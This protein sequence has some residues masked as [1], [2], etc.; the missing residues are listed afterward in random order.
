MHCPYRKPPNTPAATATTPSNSSP[1]AMPS[2][3]TP[4]RR[5][6]LPWVAAS[7]AVIAL[8][9]SVLTPVA[10]AAPALTMPTAASH[11]HAHAR[12]HHALDILTHRDGF[13]GAL[14]Q[15][16][17]AHGRRW[18]AT[19]GVAELGSPRPMPPNGRFRIGSTTKTFVATVVLQLAA[20]HHIRLDAPVERYLPGLV[21]G[22]GNDGRA[23]TVRQLL[24]HTSGLP[25]YIDD[26]PL[27]GEQ[28][29]ADR[30]RH[31]QP[32]QLVALALQHPPL[33]APSTTWSYSN[34][35]YILAGLLIE[36]VTG[37]PYGEEITQRILRPLHLDHTL[38]PGDS[39]DI[40]GPHAH[41]YLPVG[42]DATER[43]VDITRINPSWSWAAGE[44]LSTSSDLNRFFAALLGGRLLPAAELAQMTR[45]VPA[46]Q[47]WEQY[48]GA[49]YGLGLEAIPL[50]CG[51]IA[52]GHGGDIH[53]YATRAWTT[54]NGRQV[55]LSLTLAR[56]V[57]TPTILLDIRTTLDTALCDHD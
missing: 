13:P 50:S 24:Q 4:R 7:A 52:W 23:I 8:A 22:H 30:F 33:F 19:S 37:H 6:L 16:R 36:Q 20:E 15:V 12:L 25:D 14:V 2:T 9:G 40:P 29:V 47:D 5:R 18:T 10:R 54:Q 41:G 49:S 45:A 44:M 31:Y 38:V 43:L 28:F 51:Q 56:I 42:Q 48:P 35:N 53:G 27:T 32:R 57:P 1:P 21:R 3:R 55:A 11:H 34:T 46:T 39:P 26:L 17:D